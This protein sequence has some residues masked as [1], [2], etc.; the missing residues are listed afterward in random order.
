[1]LP[2]RTQITYS[3]TFI[4]LSIALLIITFCFTLI[5]L[6]QTEESADWVAHSYHVREVVQQ[7]YSD[8]REAERTQRGYLITN[9]LTYLT[10][11]R[12]DINNANITL[13]ELNRL[14]ADNSQQERNLKRL[15]KLSQEK[16]VLLN[17]VTAAEEKIGLEAAI[18]LILTN[19]AQPK[20]QALQAQVQVML[21]EEAQ[22]LSIRRAKLAQARKLIYA[23][24]VAFF[25][26]ALTPL[27]MGLVFMHHEIARFR[28]LLSE[29]NRY[30]EQ[31]EQSNQEL[32]LVATI[33]SHDLKA[34]LR[35]IHFFIE[36]IQRD[37][38]SHLSEESA[39][40]FRRVQTA[41]EKMQKLIE[42]VLFIARRQSAEAHL[43]FNQ[44]NLRQLMLDVTATLEPQI[45]ESNGV[46]DIGDMCSVQGDKLALAQLLQN[47]I[48]NGLK[49]HK[50]GVAPKINVSAIKT[51]EG[52]C[53]IR[54]QDNGIGI[55]PEHQKEI[56]EMFKRSPSQRNT[57][58]G[59][60]VGLGIVSRIVKHHNGSMQIE[61]QPGVGSVFIVQLPDSPRNVISQTGQSQTLA[62]PVAK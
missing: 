13:T 38:Q 56:F 60:G 23:S 48:E 35:K 27:I 46:V 33:A 49:Y 59:Y 61:S 3:L 54:V 11:F 15:E 14:V 44:V 32:A 4:V 7:V 18:K 20:M 28:A 6:R 5:N 31:L 53:E 26:I 34:P 50:P 52:K 57:A 37:P 22:L 9:D 51:A 12:K 17:R 2:S 39:D 8:L 19:Q 1:M 43:N 24:S 55:E 47:L 21:N 41:T 45:R 25:L 29:R 58:A 10:A 30:A 40:F 16:L 42:H 62:Y 36:Q